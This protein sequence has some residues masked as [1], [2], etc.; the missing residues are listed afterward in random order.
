MCFF[1]HC[2]IGLGRVYWKPILS[3]YVKLL[4]SYISGGVL[5]QA[6][7]VRMRVMLLRKGEYLMLSFELHL[8]SMHLTSLQRILSS[9]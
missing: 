8:S 4:C 5:A 6:L 3:S 7:V 2:M 9:R 1:D